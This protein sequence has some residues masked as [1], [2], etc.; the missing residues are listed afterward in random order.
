MGLCVNM[1]RGRER[2]PATEWLGPRTVKACKA[3][4]GRS[5]GFRE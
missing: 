2:P 1:D 4:G 5:D 3:L